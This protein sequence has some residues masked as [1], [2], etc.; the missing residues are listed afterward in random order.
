MSTI[1]DSKPD[2]Q[3]QV[4]SLAVQSANF[5]HL[6]WDVAWYGLAFGS[7]LSFLPVFATRLGAMGWQLALLTAG[8]ALISLLFTLPAASWLEYRPLGTAVT[9]TA[10]WQ[11]LGFFFLIPLPLVLPASLQVWA[12]LLLTLLMAI[13][14]TAL[15]VGFNALLAATIPPAARGQVIGRRNALLG[16]TIMIAYVL[17]GWILDRLTFEW[18]YAV[19]FALGAVGG[20]LSTFHIS[21]IH[22]PTIPQ[23]Q[24][25]PLRDHAQP[26]RVVGFSGAVPQRLTIGLRLWLN[27]RP[28]I[29][30]DLGLVSSRYW[31]AMNAFFLFHFTQMLPAALFPMFWVR[32]VPLTDGQIGWMNGLFYLT[33]LLGASLLGPLTVRLG[34]YYLTAGGAILLSLYPLLTALSTDFTLLLLTNLIGG[35]IWAILSGALTNRLLELTPEENRPTHLALYNLALNMAMLCGTM[36]GP[37]L[38]GGVGLRE[39]LLIIFALRVGS[40]LALARWG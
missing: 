6:Y 11:R 14:G 23:F 37:L 8:P 35:F 16:A 28:T 31:R 19:V 34:N 24:G 5:F 36:L 18:G 2:L 38:A 21:R 9:R 17:S 13:P 22:V 30:A 4:T 25:R 39:A 33:M 29:G 7:T 27:P 15:M 12:V 1:T 40:G 10:F 26:G 32:E 20:G 3:L